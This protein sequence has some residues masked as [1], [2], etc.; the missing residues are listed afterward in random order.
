MKL[1]P[2]LALS[3]GIVMVLAISI[4]PVALYAIRHL[5]AATGELIG[6]Q[7]PA[8]LDI[9]RIRQNL[10][11]EYSLLLQSV[12]SPN[13][14]TKQRMASSDRQMRDSLE[15]ARQHF[16]TKDDKAALDE[17]VRSYVHLQNAIAIWQAGQMNP[18]NIHEELPASFD[19]T[20]FAL[21][22]LISI[23]SGAM[24]RTAK[25]TEE[26]ARRM[27]V[28]LGVLAGMLLLLGIW[29][30]LRMVRGI[31]APV[32]QLGD[33]VQRLGEGDFD[34]VFKRGSIE[35]FDVLGKHFE[36]M[37]RALHRFRATNLDQLVAE[38][39]RNAA[40]LDSIDDGLVIFAETGVIERINPVAERQLGVEVGAAIGHSFEEVSGNRE[41]GLR[42]HEVLNGLELSHEAPPELIVKIGEDQRILAYSLT[43]FAESGGSRSG[44]VLV[45]R[46]VTIERAF[47]KMRSEFVL[48]ASHELRTPVT[49]IRMGLG[50]LA[51][52]LSFAPGTRER[53][54]YD[55]VQ[56]ELQRMVHLLT[57]LLD[58]SRLQAGQQTLER[59]PTDIHGLLVRAKQRFDLQ[60]AQSGIRLELEV[61]NPLPLISL[62]CAQ[63]DRVLDNLIVNAL[64]HT[65]SGGTI[66]LT[67]RIASAERVAIGVTDTGEGIAPT[68]HAL[69]FQPFVQ[70]GGR[71]GGAGLGLAICKE[72]VQQ[73][74]GEIQM[75]S[76]RGR[77]TA[78][79]LLLPR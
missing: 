26:F 33:L 12:L 6:D 72:L 77:G 27:F 40:V 52:K 57:D 21:G 35:E 1:Q 17:F 69:I 11:D 53:E 67:G 18:K 30:M 42:I 19:E 75:S 14:E 71:R 32:R 20:R 39:R 9:D 23:K 22:K 43:R 65:P 44:A 54:L 70:V 15:G 59:V 66:T 29:A 28:L 78:F 16:V 7:A 73:H 62:D 63:F 2:R 51:E 24:I 3:H 76:L 34:I 31:T 38:Q 74:G 45:L 79:S 55:T 37:G 48:R 5:A 10:G 50:M 58:L 41:I 13:E 61:E 56:A 47:N 4:F 8:L 25:E 68:Q 60:A 64:R 36:T 46:D 49:S